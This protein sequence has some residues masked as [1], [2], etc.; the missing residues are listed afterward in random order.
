MFLKKS[1]TTI[2][3]RT[4]TQYKIAESY[5]QD[6]KVKHR[7]LFPIGKLTDEEA[8][9]LR[10]AISAH[11]NPEVIVAKFDDLVVTKHLAYLDIACLHHFWQDWEFNKF[12]INETWI[13]PMV[14]NRCIDPMSKINIK[15]W[16]TRTILPAITSNDICEAN[17]YEIYRELD[18]LAKLELELQ[19]FIF[20]KLTERQHC[21]DDI[22][23]YDI[24]SSYFEGSKCLIAKYGYSRDHRPDN[25][26][27]VIALMIT[28]DGYPFYW[29][30]MEGNTTDI[31]TVEALVANIK[32]R[33]KIKT[34]TLVFDRGM[35]SADNLACIEQGELWYISAMDKNEIKKTGIL[36]LAIP[37]AISLDNW[38]QDLSLREFQSVNKNGSLYYREFT[39]DGCRYVVSFDVV[40]FLSDRKSRQNRL[41]Q[42][43]DWIKTKNQE[44]AQAKKSRQLDVLKNEVKQLLAKNQV[45]KILDVKIGP[46]IV[47]V[48]NKKGQ[49]RII[50]TFCLDPEF[51]IQ[52]EQE[53]QRLDGITCFISNLSNQSCSAVELIGN[54]RRKNKVEEAFREIKS[55]I[56]L[57]PIHLTRVQRVKAH[58]M[59]CMLAYFL[60]NDIELLLKAKDVGLSP[61]SV[62]EKLCD[63]QVDQITVKGNRKSR[64]QITEPSDEQVRLLQDLS[65]EYLIDTKYFRPLL[66]NLEI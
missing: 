8:E 4:Y 10:L 31:T 35:V 56:C 55:Y 30:V 7:I 43:Q 46:Y 3:G 2:R 13:E 24:T 60:H 50:N 45:K 54:Y 41:K 65:C 12:F 19:N 17:E 64:L 22:L 29:Q 11:S 63:C 40:R 34:C 6:G 18:R 36:D 15:D 27:V 47:V 5:R 51:C 16:S 1:T 52:A 28:K 33:F 39:Q 37:E 42:V 66:K 23:F 9:R 26:Q 62:L 21:L 25:Q 32:Q 38:K 58:V 49:E 53:E 59:V 48:K 61:L 20:Q 14:I 57:R 44:L